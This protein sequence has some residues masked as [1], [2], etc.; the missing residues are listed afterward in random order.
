ML[1]DEDREYKSNDESDE[2]EEETNASLY[3][4][5]E[6]SREYALSEVSPCSEVVEDPRTSA[7]TPRRPVSPSSINNNDDV[8][9]EIYIEKEEEDDWTKASDEQFRYYDYHR[10]RRRNYAIL[11]LG[12]MLI[13]LAII[14][15]SVLVIPPNNNDT[16]P[17]SS[18]AAVGS[19]PDEP[20]EEEETIPPTTLAPTLSR[21]EQTQQYVLAVLNTCPGEQKTFTDETTDVGYVYKY[22]V[23]DVYQNYNASSSFEMADAYIREKFALSMLYLKTSGYQWNNHQNWM[24]TPDPCQWYGIQCSNN[25]NDASSSFPPQQCSVTGI[26]L[27]TYVRGALAPRSSIIYILMDVMV[28]DLLLLLLF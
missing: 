1:D 27:G 17:R 6:D 18:S 26:Q 22:L 28:V 9:I 5:A 2:E 12:C 4:I 20:E 14:L 25:N 13:V 3:S 24:T 11:M 23:D 19:D 15:V 16:Q 10:R 8:G 21:L 7:A